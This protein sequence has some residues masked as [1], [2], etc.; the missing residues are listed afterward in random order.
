MQNQTQKFAK[1]GV[2][3]NG[4]LELADY[5]LDNIH[6]GRHLLWPWPAPEPM[7]GGTPQKPNDLFGKFRDGAINAVNKF[8]H[9]S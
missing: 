2:S 6:G 3:E 4:I 1:Q 5:D 8:L 7:P 9:K